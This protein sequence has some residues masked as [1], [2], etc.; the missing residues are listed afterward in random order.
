MPTNTSFAASQAAFGPSD[1]RRI[2][3]DPFCEA[4]FW[5][6]D[7]IFNPMGTATAFLMIFMAFVNN[8]EKATSHIPRLFLVCKG[9]L[10]VTGMG[11]VFFHATSPATMANAHINHGLCDW[12]PIIL[13]CS[14][15]LI[16]YLSQLLSTR[17]STE[18]GWVVLLTGVLVW[19]FVLVVGM[20]SDTNAHFSAELG[21]SG[22]Q[23]QYGTILNVALLVPLA[24]VLAYA[25]RY[26]LPWRY[27][28]GLVIALAISV[29]LWL[30][31]AYLCRQFLWL[32]VFHAI[33]HV[34]I[35]YAFLY[36]ACL[37]V[38]ID[39]KQWRFGLSP[40]GWPLVHVAPGYSTT[41]YNELFWVSDDMWDTMD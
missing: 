30:L 1:T 31:N 5:G 4:E 3:D 26:R 14:N 36:A 17:D 35:A 29:T 23:G 20:D 22:E 33:Y 8:F 24:L 27:F 12:F 10:A 34:T 13:L 2:L 15:I 38:A 37:G 7:A 40:W 19:V 6:T 9:A 25:G 11:T 28:R 16:L 39:D 18:C 32:S 41:I 21:T